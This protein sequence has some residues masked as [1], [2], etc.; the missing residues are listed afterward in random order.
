M[1]TRSCW[2]W[3]VLVMAHISFWNVSK[4]NLCIHPT[5]SARP[6]SSSATHS[7]AVPSMASCS[8]CF[9]RHLA[10]CA[11][12]LGCSDAGA[13]MCVYLHQSWSQLPRNPLDCTCSLWVYLLAPQSLSQTWM[14]DFN[15]ASLKTIWRIET[16]TCVQLDMPEK[17]LVLLPTSLT[18]QGSVRRWTHEKTGY[19]LRQLPVPPLH[20]P[21]LQI[22]PY[23][24][25]LCL[26]SVL[27]TTFIHPVFILSEVSIFTRGCQH[28]PSRSHTSVFVLKIVYV[29]VLLDPQPL[30]I[31]FSVFVSP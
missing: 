26:D 3:W 29:L 30:S 28:A 2:S 15:P 13:A 23:P 8:S 9:G 18:S 17:E 22:S 20:Q 10:I 25:I 5:F 19:S 12:H 21:Y 4:W 7:R 16:W 24:A 11:Q 1:Y 6:S 27:S 14:L 31:H